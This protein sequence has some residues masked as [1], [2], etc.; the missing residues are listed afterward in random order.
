MVPLEDLKTIYLMQ[1]LTDPLLEK[2][3][4]MVESRFYEDRDVIFREGEKAQGFFMLLKG[5]ILL[6]V[7]A[8]EAMMIVL[9][10]IKPG[11]SFGWSG[12]IPGEAYTTYAIAAEPSEVLVMEGGRFLGLMEEDHAIGFRIM[13]G[14]VNILKKR[15]ERRTDQFLRTLRRHPDIQNPF[16]A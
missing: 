8:S 4:P 14:V 16:W 1:R 10:A 3:R 12:L 5:K 2:V 11:Y 15:L 13:Q 7:Q 6:E 9:G